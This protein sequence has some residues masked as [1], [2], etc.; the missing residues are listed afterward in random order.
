MTAL[1]RSA[2]APWLIGLLGSLVAFG[3]LSIDMY[4]PA[5]PR[6]AASLGVSAALAQLTIGGFLAGFCLGM[7]VYGPLS[8]RFG[9]RPLLLGGMALYIAC[10]LGC[11]L[12]DSASQLILLRFLQA[13]GGGAGSVMARAM[14]RDLYPLD[15]AAP[16]LSLLHLVTMLA[17]L[18]A[19]L[20]GG[21]LLAAAGWRA[22]FLALALFGAANLALVWRLLP[23]S[24]PAERRDKTGALVAFGA[25][26]LLLS[27]RRSLAYL[28]AN[29]LIFGGMFAFITGSPFVY[30]DYFGVSPQRYGW[31]FGLN[32]ASVMLLTLLNRR[33]CQEVGADRL[34]RWQTGTAALAGL[35]LWGFS[36]GSLPAVVLPLLLTVGLTG[37]IGPNCMARLL[38]L[39]E[40]RVG[41]AMA[42]AVSGQFGFGMA[43]SALVAL[44]QD[45]T[46]RAMCLAVAV[47]CVG[48]RLALSLS[49]SPRK[50][51][52]HASATL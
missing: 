31:L 27:D 49:P 36:G 44:R 2:P 14:V 1:S 15:C 38:Q 7:L 24:L 39:H 10:N 30:I 3:P 51:S 43:A 13:L 4:L 5:L 29:G 34:L 19:P 32:I 37:S 25:Y 46:P 48:S 41:A 40:T 45:G 22:L 8:D 17:P 21:W 11:A 16:V 9:R 42:L 33:L 20:I 18:L 23:E 50:A 52:P 47:C 35:A 12:A 26:G 6:I 28:L